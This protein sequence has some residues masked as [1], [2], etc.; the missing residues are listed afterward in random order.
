[1]KRGTR[2]GL[3]AVVLLVLGACSAQ[4]DVHYLADDSYGGRNNGSIGSTRRSYLIGGLRLM[5]AQPV[6]AGAGTDPAAYEHPFA[7]GTNIL[8]VLPGTD[9][10]HEHVL[11]GAHYDGL[12]SSCGRPTPPTRSA[13]GRPTTPPASRR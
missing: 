1:M 10:A 12:G 9:L 3:I 8:A 2:L 13:T 5:G 7:G 11:V 4:M 6:G